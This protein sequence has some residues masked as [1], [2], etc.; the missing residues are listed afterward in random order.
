MSLACPS[1]PILNT[2][3]EVGYRRYSVW[4][5]TT[6]IDANDPRVVVV[7]RP[8]IC[9]HSQSEQFRTPRIGGAQGRAACYRQPSHVRL[10]TLPILAPLPKR[11]GSA[12]RWVTHKNGDS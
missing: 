3:H 8:L 5:D 9:R 11:H 12:T 6:K 4:H 10:G 2:C 1:H 7:T